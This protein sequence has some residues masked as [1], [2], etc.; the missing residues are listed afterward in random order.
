[1]RR[2]YLDHVDYCQ[3]VNA[4]NVPER[5]V[6]L[7]FPPRHR[8]LKFLRIQRRGAAHEDVVPVT[9]RALMGYIDVMV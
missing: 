6:C 2:T 4:D 5:S 9:D 8:Q 1:M 3:Q 7:F